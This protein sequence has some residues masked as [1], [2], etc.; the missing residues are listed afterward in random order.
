MRTRVRIDLDLVALLAQLVPQLRR[1]VLE[2]VHLAELVLLLVLGQERVFVAGRQFRRHVLGGVHGMALGLIRLDVRHGREEDRIPRRVVEL[3][4]GDVV[5]GLL[6]QAPGPHLVDHAVH[7]GPRAL[8]LSGECVHG[9]PPT[10]R[11]IDDLLGFRVERTGQ[12]RKQGLV[13]V[14][15]VEVLDGVADGLHGA[16]EP[17][18]DAPAD[19]GERAAAGVRQPLGAPQHVLALGVRHLGKSAAAL[20]AVGVGQ[21]EIFNHGLLE[22]QLA[23]AVDQDDSAVQAEL[24]P[25]AHGLGRYIQ[26]FAQLLQRDDAVVQQADHLVEIARQ[27]GAVD[28]QVRVGVRAEAGDAVTDERIRVALARVDLGKEP[29]GLLGLVQTPGRRGEPHLL[30]RQLFQGRMRKASHSHTPF[31]GFHP[32]RRLEILAFVLVRAGKTQRDHPADILR[33]AARCKL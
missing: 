21:Q 24:A 3:G 31:A 12:V 17:L 7:R 8:E 5:E 23:L 25:A 30:I 28:Q 27:I 4:A 1:L 26:L 14:L 13:G 20:H 16:A 11:V 6:Q 22:P 15:A 32:F 29:P 18:G 19:L 10:E 9:N 2:V 33:Y